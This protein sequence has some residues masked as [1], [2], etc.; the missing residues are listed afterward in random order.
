M[1]TLSILLGCRLSESQE[2]QQPPDSTQSSAL[3]G[4]NLNSRREGSSRGFRD[5][6]AYQRFSCDASGWT[7]LLLLLWHLHSAPCQTCTRTCTPQRHPPVVYWFCVKKKINT[8]MYIINFNLLV[9]WLMSSQENKVVCF[10]FA[11]ISLDC[12]CESLGGGLTKPGE[13]HILALCC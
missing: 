5:T 1:R 7:Y 11:V 6:R 9:S 13:G 10:R 3:L 2:W 8:L 12:N 4:M